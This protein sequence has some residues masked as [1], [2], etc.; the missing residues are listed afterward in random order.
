MATWCCRKRNKCCLIYG[1]NSSPEQGV[2]L[3]TLVVVAVAVA[4][5]GV[6]WTDAPD[7]R[8][9]RQTRSLHDMTFPATVEADSQPS[10]KDLSPPFPTFASPF[11]HLRRELG[12]IFGP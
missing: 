9:P 12:A 8:R 5:G 6:G 7:G 10:Q 2:A 4:V 1:V 3:R 11:P